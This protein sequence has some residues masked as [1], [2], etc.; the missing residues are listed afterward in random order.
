LMAKPMLVTFPFV[1]L[2][3]D[4]WP[5]ARWKEST[6]ASLAREKIP[7]ILLVVGTSALTFVAQRASGAVRQL[8]E[9]SLGFRFE[10]ALLSYLR[11]IGK[12]LWPADLSALYPFPTSIDPWKI[13]ATIFVLIGVTWLVFRERERRPYLIVG[14]LWYVGTLVPVVGFVQVGYQA[15]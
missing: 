4:Y 3:L 8:G 2:L 13:V 6:W 12:L 10:N 5:L 9:V 15:M 14:W 11:S 1:L 7:L